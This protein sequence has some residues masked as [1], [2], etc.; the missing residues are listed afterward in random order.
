MRRCFVVV[1]LMIVGSF[2]AKWLEN[3]I[4]DPF[5]GML[6]LKLMLW[7]LALTFVY[8]LL[9]AIFFPSPVAVVVVGSRRRRRW[10]KGPFNRTFRP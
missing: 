9:K 5:I 6:Y 4:G 7:V 1:L 10:F 2:P 3:L 8:G